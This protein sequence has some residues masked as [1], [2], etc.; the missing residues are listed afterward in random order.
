MHKSA[1]AIVLLGLLI[2]SP[3]AG[4]ETASPVSRAAKATSVVVATTSHT[5]PAGKTRRVKKAAT[6]QSTPPRPVW[7]GPDP[8]KGPGI[9]RLHQLQREGRCVLDEGYG[10]FT[11]CS[12]R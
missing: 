5:S 1:T 10:R 6:A 12:D 8:T 2:V 11:Y 3:A 9:E 4:Q 7:T